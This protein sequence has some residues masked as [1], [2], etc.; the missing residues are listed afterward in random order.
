MRGIGRQTGVHDRRYN[1]PR[2][3]ACA[4]R[5]SRIRRAA[6]GSAIKWERAAASAAAAN[7]QI[8]WSDPTGPRSPPHVLPQLRR[9]YAAQD[10]HL[11]CRPDW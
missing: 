5:T 8:T 2:R 9:V 1:M 6:I 4:R 10:T 7:T 3:R 11:H